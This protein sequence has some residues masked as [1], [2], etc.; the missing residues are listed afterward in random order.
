MTRGM[1][2]RYGAIK[3]KPEE[4]PEDTA[5]ILK[6]FAAHKDT[7]L[8]LVTNGIITAQ[9]AS[10]CAPTSKKPA[11]P[12]VMVDEDIDLDQCKGEYDYS[13]Y[14][15]KYD[16]DI[17]NG[18]LSVRSKFDSALIYEMDLSEKGKEHQAYEERKPTIDEILAKL[19]NKEIAQAYALNNLLSMVPEALDK[20]PAEDIEMALIKVLLFP[21]FKLLKDGVVFTFENEADLDFI[22]ENTIKNSDKKSL[23]FLM[24]TITEAYMVYKIAGH[25]IKAPKGIDGEYSPYASKALSVAIAGSIKREDAL[26]DFSI[27][28]RIRTMHAVNDS[29]P[30]ALLVGGENYS[31]DPNE[32]FQAKNHIKPHLYDTVEQLQPK[33]MDDKWL[34]QLAGNVDLYYLLHYLYPAFTGETK[35]NLIF[36]NPV[37]RGILLAPKSYYES[38]DVNGIW[39]NFSVFRLEELR[40]K[41]SEDKDLSEELY[42]KYSYELRSS[43]KEDVMDLIP[44]LILRKKFHKASELISLISLDSESEIPACESG[45]P[46]EFIAVTYAFGNYRVKDSILKMLDTYDLKYL[47]EK[48]EFNLMF[49]H[50][51]NEERIKLAKEFKEKTYLADNLI[52][53]LNNSKDEQGRLGVIDFALEIDE[54]LSEKIMPHL[55]VEEKVYF[56]NKHSGYYSDLEYNNWDSY[57]EWLDTHIT[58]KAEPPHYATYIKT[59]IT[60]FELDVFRQIV[61]DTP[62]T[63]IPP[64]LC[65]VLDAA[66]HDDYELIEKGKIVLPDFKDY[67]EQKGIKIWGKEEED[68]I[69]YALT[70]LTPEEIVSVYDKF[71]VEYFRRYPPGIILRMPD[72][73]ENGISGEKTALL[74]IAK[75]DWND[76]F[77]QDKDLY[78]KL[79]KIDYSIMV[80][81]TYG[82]DEAFQFM[83]EFAKKYEP[84]SLLIL[85]GHGKPS[86]ISLSNVLGHDMSSIDVYDE[87]ELESLGKINLVKKDGVVTLF[88]C[89][90]GA[91]D[92][93]IAALISDKLNATVYAPTVPTSPTKWIIDEDSETVIGVE[94]SESDSTKV[95]KPK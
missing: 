59:S 82:D 38:D 47:V 43:S 48:K 76:A 27:F 62:K 35:D 20:G 8:K 63:N 71:N 15:S 89:S 3:R 30:I 87:T 16:F 50:S 32:L 41:V 78:A 74:I 80:F 58:Y 88:S 86:S 4:K 84:V 53:A 54:S 91:S 77:Y 93:S 95:F 37:I 18:V 65:K 5:W 42:A 45:E 79:I 73:I 81:E 75:S 83:E 85:A 57:L 25:R 26:G 14:R 29:S 19:E 90:T 2:L 92:N 1:K 49:G 69:A 36:N 94:Y 64:R 34:D 33:K 60:L 24:D 68:N 51:D 66:F 55:S 10:A 39:S 44:D 7:V 23:Y 31:W 52:S 6:K 22:L 17:N 28:S 72:M 61:R 70:L 11:T 40:K 9:L 21:D 12:T 46:G 56:L 13:S 67:F